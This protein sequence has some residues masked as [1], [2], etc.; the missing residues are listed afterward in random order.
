MIKKVFFENSQGQKLA[1]VLIVPD[2]EGKF[3][4][5]L[6]L[7]GFR[8]GKDS[9]SG[10][11]FDE[12]FK[13]DYIYLRFDFFAHGESEGE[14]ENLTPSEEIDDAKAAID[15]VTK[16]E[17]CN[18]DVGLI[19]SSLGGMV[20][21]YAAANDP[22]VKAAMFGAP[23]SDFKT[24]FSKLEDIEAWK[25]QGWK[26]TYNFEGQKFK[27][28]FDFFEDGCQYDLY[29]EADKIEVPVLVL[30]GDLDES[31]PMEHTQELMK[32]LKNGKL[33]ILKGAKHHWASQ[34][35]HFKT[36]VDKTVEFFKENL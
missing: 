7:H 17:Q 21:I 19:G 1:G 11:V 9:R 13:E 15:F 29:Q 22:R 30:Q 14:F 20:A 25:E 10:V 27:I 5:I 26:Y 24:C 28:K 4:A 31:I 18:G 6:R 32:H 8:S 36:F 23:V 34:P 33:E 35:E 2:K 12:K 3:P 16:L